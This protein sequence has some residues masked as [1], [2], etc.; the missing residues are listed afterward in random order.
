MNHTTLLPRR[1]PSTSVYQRGSSAPGGSGRRVS[2]AALER[3]ILCLVLA[4][5]LAISGC[6]TKPT[7][8]H[9]FPR[10]VDPVTE[11]VPH[12]RYSR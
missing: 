8:R 3:F 4:S 6:A 11:E 9:P 1:T 12:V 7:T 10:F 5:V 2:A